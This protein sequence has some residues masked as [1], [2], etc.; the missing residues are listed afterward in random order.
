VIGRLSATALCDVRLQ[1]RNGFYYAAA[2]VA[3]FSIVVLL[4]LPAATA[5]WLMP[6]FI[7][8]NLQINT[9]YFVGGLVLLEKG[10]G[11][12]LAQ[13]VTP[14]KSSEYLVSKAATLT[15]LAVVENFMIAAIV[16]GV[17]FA[18]APLIA[19]MTAASLIYVFAGFILASRYDSISD[20]LFPSFLYTLA[21]APP[22]LSYAG[23][24]SS[25][26]IYLHPLQAALVLT[27]AGFYDMPGWRWPYGVLYSIVCIAALLAWSRRAFR[28]F[29]SAAEGAR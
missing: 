20:Y 6:L 27:Q 5:R 16:S 24:W 18:A 21:F 17:R 23:L 2:F 29:V 15:A 19:G 13:S 4:Q 14:L 22:V 28:V 10:E 25:G 9:F 12:L 26:W 11:T 3:V 1:W 8:G 7:L